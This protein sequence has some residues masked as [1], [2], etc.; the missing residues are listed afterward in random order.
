MTERKENMNIYYAHSKLIYNT[1][2]EQ[3][4]LRFL[5]RKFKDCKIVYANN[6]SELISL[7]EYLKLV[8]ECEIVICSEFKGHVGKGVF[9]GLQKALEKGK[10][11]KVLKRKLGRFRLKTLKD[12]KPD[13]IH[14]WK[15]KY[16]LVIC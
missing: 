5:K 12:I 10:I 4:E 7:A 9:E 6:I 16:G 3:Q 1:K 15:V 2:R 8:Q 11:I 14:D 13:N